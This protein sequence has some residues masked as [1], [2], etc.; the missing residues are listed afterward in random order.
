MLYNRKYKYLL[1]RKGSLMRKIFD[2]GFTQSWSKSYSKIKRSAFTL[3]EVLIVLGIIGIVASMTIPTLMN[4]V[5]KQEYVA[6]LKKFYSTQMNGWAQLLA[7]EGVQQLVDTSLWQ[8]M[9]GDCWILDANDASCKP[10]FDGLKKYFRFSVVTAPSYQT[11]ALKGTKDS[12]YI[13]YP[14][15]A[16]ADGSVM[17]YGVFYKTADKANAARSAQ[18]AARGGHLYSWQGWFYIDVN[19]FKKPNTIGR[20][21]FRFSISGDG[22]LYP[23]GGKD[24]ALYPGS[25]TWQKSSTYCGTAG[26]TDVSGA[27]G[28]GC[29]ARIMDEGWQMNY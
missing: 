11:Y 25:W 19:G 15:L 16:F 9:T 28:N 22:K 3:A 13:G 20:D 4:K 18:I 14:V 1:R 6:G 12:N 23:E 27:Y 10:F 8:N 7:D 29:A 24:F 21:I 17:A 26:S 5:A 2:Q